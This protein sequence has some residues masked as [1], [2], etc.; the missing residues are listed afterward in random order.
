MVSRPVPS[1]APPD[2]L[3][4]PPHPGWLTGWAWRLRLDASIRSLSSHRVRSSFSMRAASFSS[5]DILH[6]RACRE[7]RSTLTGVPTT[8]VGSR[9][10]G[11]GETA[12]TV[13][14][15]LS[16]GGGGGGA[17]KGHGLCSGGHDVVFGMI[18]SQNKS[19]SGPPGA[20]HP[21]WRAGGV[22]GSGMASSL[23]SH[24]GSSC[25]QS[26]SA[27]PSARGDECATLAVTIVKRAKEGA[28]ILHRERA[29][30]NYEDP[31]S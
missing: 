15:P 17:W 24:A 22:G 6:G 26:A 28:R 27:M 19:G 16:G 12:A 21:F 3:I 18:S 29:T 4:V 7:T 23:A 31:S 10:D 1:I 5:S 14:G 8:R 11:S 30:T 13:G 25:G 2:T 20:A 9:E